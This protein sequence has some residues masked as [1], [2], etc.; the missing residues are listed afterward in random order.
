MESL[1]SSPHSDPTVDLIA[2][3]QEPDS[4]I[5]DWRAGVLNILLPVITLAILPALIQTIYQVFIYRGIGWVGPSIYIFF[6]LVLVYVALRWDM[7]STVRGWFLV[8]LTF[9]TGLVAMARGGLAGDGRIYLVVVPVLAIMLINTNMGLYTAVISLLAYCAF[10]ILAEVGILDQWLIRFDN[11]LDAEYWLY[12]GLTMG[13]IVIAIVFLVV[14]FSKF[15]VQTLESSKK[16][17]RALA[18]A[19]R[20]LETVNVQLEQKVQ[21]RT[22]ELR[23]VNRRLEFLATHDSLTGLPNRLLLYD[24]LDQAVK[25]S[26]RGKTSFALFFIDLDDFK[27]VNDTFGHAVG[28]HVLQA[29]GEALS[30]SVRVS[31]TVARL[32]G[33]EFALILYDV[34]GVADV[35][36]VAHKISIALSHP[37]QD[38]DEKITITASVGVSLFPDHGSDADSLLRKADQAMYGAK[39][40]GKNRYLLAA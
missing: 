12:S 24:R 16:I 1:H 15:Q 8:G 2:Q 36:I 10:G 6:Y 29:V 23:Q 7:D 39:N 18:N 13:T 34:H 32:A 31:D 38:M 35:E 9:L 11:P 21:E 17:A 37:L 27:K 5:Q 40:D 25:K 33:D 3:A 22:L 20:Q 4:I 30:Q 19:Y 28:D 14:R 26:R